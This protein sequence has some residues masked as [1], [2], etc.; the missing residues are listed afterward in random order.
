MPDTVEEAI[1]D[2]EAFY[3][4]RLTAMSHSSYELQANAPSAAAIRA[5]W[6]REANERNEAETFKAPDEMK[7]T[8]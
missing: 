2:A 4:R 8:P 7:G 5:A 6:E 1:A 3:A